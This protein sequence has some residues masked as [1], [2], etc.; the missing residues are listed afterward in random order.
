METSISTN[1]AARVVADEKIHQKER[2]PKT[3]ERDPVNGLRALLRSL[4]RRIG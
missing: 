2:E 3:L 1:Y 4:V